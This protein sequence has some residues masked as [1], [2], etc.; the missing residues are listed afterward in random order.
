MTFVG[1]T[2][3]GL[4]LLT[5]CGDDGGGGGSGGAGYCDQLKDAKERIDAI[6]DGD[7]GDFEE[8]SETVNDLADAAPDEIKDDWGVLK[9][10]FDAI[11]A[12]FEEAGIDSEDLEAIQKGEIPPDVDMEKLQAAF[13]DLEE[14]SGDKFTTASDNISKHAKEECDVDLDA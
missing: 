12:A 6:D 4:S 9:E 2:A 14:L 3:L 11:L 8:L 1:A 13:A 7:F 10:G 5:G